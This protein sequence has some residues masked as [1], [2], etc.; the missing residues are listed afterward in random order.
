MRKS[1]PDEKRENER[2]GRKGEANKDREEE[3]EKEP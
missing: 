2:D 3:R 1:G